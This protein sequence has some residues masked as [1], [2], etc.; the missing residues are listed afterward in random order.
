MCCGNMSCLKIAK[1]V[2][3]FLILR[4]SL[5]VARVLTG[6][7]H[8]LSRKYMHWQE[9]LIVGGTTKNSSGSLLR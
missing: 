5:D 8:G 3:F 9:E 6:G 1:F 7:C 4:Q 2:F